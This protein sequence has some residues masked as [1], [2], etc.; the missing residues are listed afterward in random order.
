MNKRGVGRMRGGEDCGRPVSLQEHTIKGSIRP[1]N[2][3]PGKSAPQQPLLNGQVERRD[4]FLRACGG[5]FTHVA[6]RNGRLTMALHNLTLSP[7]LTTTRTSM[8]THAV[9]M[10]SS[11]LWMLPVVV[12][13]QFAF[14][15]THARRR[16]K[17]VGQLQHKYNS[18]RSRVDAHLKHRA[19]M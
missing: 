2:T 5:R 6:H 1:C 9:T 11:S 4:T 7:S 10:K 3:Q 17:V 8:E 12:L 14:R 15:R 19:K 18:L 13:W 16:P